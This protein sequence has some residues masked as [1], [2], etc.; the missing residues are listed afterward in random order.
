MERK[1]KDRVLF[2]YD[3]KGRAKVAVVVAKD[4][5]HRPGWDPETNASCDPSELPASFTDSTYEIWTVAA[6]PPPT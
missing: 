6:C 4:Q 3:V 1:E 5:P 2:S